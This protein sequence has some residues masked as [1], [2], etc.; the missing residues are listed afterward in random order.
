M[1][2]G[3][4]GQWQTVIERIQIVCG[5]IDVTETSDEWV[6]TVTEAT[7]L[8]E[9]GTS[10]GTPFTAVCPADN[11]VVGFSGRSGQKLDAV[12]LSCAPLGVTSADSG[13]TL[14]VNLGNIIEIEVIG[15]GGGTEF[16]PLLCGSGEA[17]TT[18][19]IRTADNINGLGLSC[20]KLEFG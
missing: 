3:N 20:S 16:G 13:P 4:S 9:R 8:P 1:N 7:V 10:M 2:I 14:D 19:L 5:R 11:A 15:G 17:V 6:L 12:G 18:A